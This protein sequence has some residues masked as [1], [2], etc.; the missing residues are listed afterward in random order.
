MGGVKSNPI[1]WV[2]ECKTNCANSLRNTA[3]GKWL[4]QAL[5]GVNHW[6]LEAA[7]YE[8]CLQ[9]CTQRLQKV[10]PIGQVKAIGLLEVPAGLDEVI[11]ENQRLREENEKL[12][13]D[14]RTY[15]KIRNGKP[16]ECNYDNR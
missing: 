13:A 12:R 11:A 6:F 8:T 4:G 15:P 10:L 5:D 16:S 2:E 14:L 1:A 3:V 9:A 7:N